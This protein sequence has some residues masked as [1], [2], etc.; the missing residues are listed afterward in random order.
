ML[1]PVQLRTL[2]EVLATGS[3][4]EA[5]VHLGFT[6]SAV[7]QQIAALERSTGL[8]L[9]DRGPR[10]IRPTAAAQ[11]LSRRVHGL[12]GQLDVL[13]REIRVMAAGG[14]GVVR[15]GSFPT[16]SAG[17]L[18]AALARLKRSHPELDVLLD[19]AEPDE[20]IP[21]LAAG[22]LD[23]ILVYEYDTVPQFW[24][25]TL[26]RTALLRESLVLLVPQ[27]QAALEQGDAGPLNLVAM[28]DA[29]WAASR[30]ETA[31]ARSLERLC[32]AA[33]FAPRVA[34]RSNDYGVIRGLVAA[35]LGVAIV[36]ALA[37]VQDPKT[38]AVALIAPGASRQVFALH[39][40]EDSNPV[41]GIVLNALTLAGRARTRAA[42]PLS[43]Q[44][45]SPIPFS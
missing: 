45:L 30:E 21:R 40:G 36:P 8:A 28:A 25:K 7:S 38:L 6:A 14:L 10:S 2:H 15:I 29:T 42:S 37:H 18:P 22:V 1:Q 24:P 39:R 17:L 41:L 23:L 20:L 31:G 5:G 12:L 3:F 26:H 4:A 11:A 19:E 35:S 43:P 33:G 32:A 34:Y 13:E 16:A 44:P 27:S 9:F